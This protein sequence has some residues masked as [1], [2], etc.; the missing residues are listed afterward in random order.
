M[1]L[2]ESV[3][4]LNTLIVGLETAVSSKRERISPPCLGP[5]PKDVLDESEH[6]IAITI[7]SPKE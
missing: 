4:P 6:P 3:A 1:F 5:A 2:V 7:S